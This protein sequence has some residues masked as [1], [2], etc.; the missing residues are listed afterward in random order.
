[1]KFTRKKGI[2]L[3]VAVILLGLGSIAYGTFTKNL[4][5]FYTPSEVIAFPENR[6]GKK[7]KV[8]GLVVKQSIKITPETRDIHFNLTDQIAVIPVVFE[9][10]PPDL[11]KEGQGAVVEGY[12]GSDKTFHSHLI[13]AKHSEDYMPP[14]MKKAGGTLPKKDFFKTLNLDP[15][16]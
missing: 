13:M 1:M 5:Y 4:V 9:G 12:W 16:K 2:I 15:G 11:F 10:V 7:I 8:A 14:D 6:T 3:S